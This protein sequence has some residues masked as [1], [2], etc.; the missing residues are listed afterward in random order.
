[1]PG[2]RDTPGLGRMLELTV[3][4]FGRDQVPTIILYQL[5]NFSYL[6]T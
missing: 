6:H 5:E 3:A 2:D 1:M 4:A